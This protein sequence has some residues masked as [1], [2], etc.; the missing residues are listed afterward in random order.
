M[1]S[2]TEI[3]FENTMGVPR[4]FYLD[5]VTIEDLTGVY[6]NTA[7]VLSAHDYYAFGSPMREEGL[8]IPFIDMGSMTRRR[9]MR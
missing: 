2:N 7:E 3:Y 5:N 8:I 6:Y 1:S 4:D 9:I